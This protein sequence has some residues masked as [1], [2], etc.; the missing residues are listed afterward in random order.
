MYKRYAIE[1]QAIQ[2]YLEEIENTIDFVFDD[3]DTVEAMEA[4]GDGKQYTYKIA[5]LK[6]FCRICDRY[7]FFNIATPYLFEDIETDDLIALFR[8]AIDMAEKAIKEKEK[9]YGI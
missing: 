4:L 6:F 8:E 5:F 2:N 1:K 9:E 7:D 3:P